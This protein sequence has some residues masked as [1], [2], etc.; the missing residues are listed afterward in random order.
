MGGENH[1][2]YSYTTHPDGRKYPHGRRRTSCCTLD[3]RK[4]TIDGAAF[5]QVTAI[6]RGNWN[7][8]APYQ[9]PG[10]PL[11]A[12]HSDM[13]SKRKL[14]GRLGSASVWSSFEGKS[15]AIDA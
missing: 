15:K 1:I 6:G 14:P 7:D 12:A 4:H 2:V 3:C 5:T 9:K 8:R 11:C 13:L 10:R